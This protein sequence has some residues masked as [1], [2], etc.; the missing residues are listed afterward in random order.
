MEH[1]NQLFGKKPV[2]KG[3]ITEL[4]EL[5]NLRILEKDISDNNYWTLIED[6]LKLTKNQYEQE[7]YLIEALINFNPEEI[8]GF[9]LK[10]IHFINQL[11]DIK[12]S[13]AS[14]IINGNDLTETVEHFRYWILSRGKT[15]Y[16]T[17]LIDADYLISEIS[18]E[19][20]FYDFEGFKRIAS[21][22]FKNLTEQEIA[23]YIDSKKLKT[24]PSL[25]DAI[26]WDEN[27]PE[28]LQKHCPNLFATLWK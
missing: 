16:D 17:A 27:D 8:I 25:N 5:A 21:K 6:S 10:T 3:T 14:F 28:T 1:L 2:K 12:I 13:C 9:H 19:T 18:P 26:R 23:D 15:V 4:A 22:A 11:T 20:N 7:N 24:T